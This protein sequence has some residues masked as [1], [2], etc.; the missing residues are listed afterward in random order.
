MSL[1]TENRLFVETLAENFLDATTGQ[2]GT[3]EDRVYAVLKTVSLTECAG[4][5][6]RDE[7]KKRVY[8]HYFDRYGGEDAIKKLFEKYKETTTYSRQQEFKHDPLVPD[9]V[10]AII[11]D[12][13]NSWE[14]DQS[15][16]IYLNL[17]HIAHGGR[18]V[19]NPVY[20]ECATGINAKGNPISYTNAEDFINA[21]YPG[22]LPK[23]GPIR[24]FNTAVEG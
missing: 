11:D 20:G 13:M 22:L 24:V 5:N 1:S 7:F 10:M 17:S 8:E 6:I 9:I 18:V 3:D 4:F 2:W 15:L 14:I 23:I 16:P 19:P 21:K 12:E